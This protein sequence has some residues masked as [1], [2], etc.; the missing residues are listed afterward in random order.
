M[1]KRLSMR[2]L[3]ATVLITLIVAFG[4]GWWRKCVSRYWEWKWAGFTLPADTVVYEEDPRRSP[5]LLK[6]GTPYKPLN[7]LP[8][9]GLYAE[10][11]PPA[12]AARLDPEPI[13]QLT[14]LSPLNTA[15]PYAHEHRSP[16]GTRCLVVLRFGASAMESDQQRVLSFGGG[17]F[18]PTG[19]S[20]GPRPKAAFTRNLLLWV[21]P[22]QFVRL[23]AGQPDVSDPTHFTIRYELGEGTGTIDGWVRD[24]GNWKP[25]S[26]RNSGWC[27]ES[28]ELVVRDGPAKDAK[29]TAPIWGKR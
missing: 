8:V 9:R 4:P 1:F 17:I 5:L 14:T 20:E 23:Y 11:T 12:Q 6:P 29:L 18:Y 15:T 10:M 27:G 2:L 3:G 24:P 22:N 7:L 21:K 28:V 25:K 13:E 19:W 16:S 26:P